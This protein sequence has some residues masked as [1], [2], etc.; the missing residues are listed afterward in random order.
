MK[1]SFLNTLKSEE[2]GMNSGRTIHRLLDDL[3]FQCEN[4]HL[5]IIPKGFQTDL[6]SVPRVP[7]VFMMWGD[8]AH[9]PA[10]LHDYLY[11]TNSVPLLKRA[12]ADLLFK[13]AIISTDEPWYVSRPMWLGVR[14]G[15][16]SAYHKFPVG[17]EYITAISQI[18]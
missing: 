14:A 6:A 17:H 11:R 13:I 9:R 12:E 4:E 3:V 16:C 18:L 2:I 8:R 10:V 5:I 1:P 7:I 15:G